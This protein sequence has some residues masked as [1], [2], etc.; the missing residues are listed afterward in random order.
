MIK[1]RPITALVLPLLC[2]PQLA[3]A[4][5][6]D[7]Q[8]PPVDI[9]LKQDYQLPQADAQS[10][11]ILAAA[12]G[13][14]ASLTADQRA[15]AVFP[16]A[17][18]TQRSNWS[19]FPDGAVKRQGVKRG[20][21]SAE[22]IAALDALLAQVLSAEGVRN[23]RY[24]L[25][26]DDALG[27][28]DQGG[29]GGPMPVNFGS[30]FY[31]VS[32]L[33]EPSETAPWMLQFGGHHL[34]INATVF[35]PDLSFSPMLTGGEPLHITIDGVEIYTTEAETLAAQALLDSLNDDQKK[36]AI[37]S[38]KA[39]NLLLGPGE[40]GTV[41]A[42]EGIKG[43]DLEEPQQ[44]LLLDLIH[45]RLGFA[46][47]DDSAAMMAEVEAGL[48]Q[49]WFGW[50]GPQGQPGAAYFR[51]TGP[52]LALEYAPQDGDGDPT[53]HAHNMYRNPLNDYGTA[54]IAAD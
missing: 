18:N 4:Q 20:D 40:Y 1:N 23:I 14:L 17:D 15:A 25:A 34:A 8:T 42:P 19:N 12:Q 49:T 31:Y 27:A 3:L 48:D 39:I 28:T 2:L 9:T 24:Q 51:V 11:A 21:L 45:T 37:R 6:G 44:E 7:L 35:G 36:Q 29:G 47:D 22:Q 10:R 41:L 13:F 43:S 32:F 54:W 33:G 26:G 53:D 16:F 38:D 5:Q 52:S 46:N 50:W 30:G